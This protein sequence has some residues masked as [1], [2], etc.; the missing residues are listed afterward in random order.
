MGQAG[1]V[2]HHSRWLVIDGIVPFADIL[3]ALLVISVVLAL[4]IVVMYVSLHVRS[5]KRWIRSS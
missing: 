1:Q 3:L 2:G 5:F 4:L